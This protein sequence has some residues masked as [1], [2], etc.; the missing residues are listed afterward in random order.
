MQHN[1]QRETEH[2]ELVSIERV[3]GVL[4]VHKSRNGA[5]LWLLGG[6]WEVGGSPK[7]FLNLLCSQ[8]RSQMTVGHP[9][10]Y[11]HSRRAAGI[12]LVTT[13]LCI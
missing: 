7:I 13:D 1:S 9:T 5:Y 10:W 6:Q 12:K 11:H 3:L 8:V 4:E 2:L